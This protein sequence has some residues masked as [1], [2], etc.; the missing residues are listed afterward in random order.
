MSKY[1]DADKLIKSVNNYQEG[2]K[3]AFNP[4]EDDADYYK[5]KIDACKDI[6]EFIIFLQQEQSEVEL[7]KEIDFFFYGKNFKR[8]NDG[9]RVPGALTRDWQNQNVNMSLSTDEIRRF[10][11][12]FAEW[13][14]IHL[15]ARKEE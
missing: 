11:R 8:C 10:A 3:A 6:Q 5:G 1:I 4:I 2:A 7:E 15:N 14:A 13:G 12:R 9:V